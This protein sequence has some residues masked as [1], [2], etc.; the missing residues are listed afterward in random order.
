MA[1]GPSISSALTLLFRWI[2]RSSYM[3]LISVSA[4]VNNMDVSVLCLLTVALSFGPQPSS[5]ILP[6]EKPGTCPKTNMYG[7]RHYRHVWHCQNKCFQDFQ[8]PG[9]QKCCRV[10]CQQICV[11]PEIVLPP[12]PGSCPNP[13]HHHH[14]HHHHRRHHGCFT[15]CSSDHDCMGDHKCCPSRCGQTCMKP[16]LPTPKPGTCPPAPPPPFGGFGICLRGCTSDDDCRGDHKCC[17]NGCGMV[18]MEPMRDTRPGTCPPPMPHLLPH[19]APCRDQCTEDNQCPPFLKCCYSGC[20]MQCLK[21][22]MWRG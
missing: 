2:N 14:H 8:C 4:A 1:L 7:H 17:S 20:G 21:P 5:Q 15:K 22:L 6:V 12:K 13:H 10:G 3:S 11:D 16:D 19:F 9:I 18:C